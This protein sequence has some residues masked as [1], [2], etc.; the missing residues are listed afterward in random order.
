MLPSPATRVA[1]TSPPNLFQLP[2]PPVSARPELFHPNT[3]TLT[4]TIQAV[5]ESSDQGISTLE[6]DIV[7]TLAVYDRY[8]P[9]ERRDPASATKRPAHTITLRLPHG[10]LLDG[11]A[12]SLSPRQRVRVTGYLR[13]HLEHLSLQRIWAYLKL[14]ERAQLGDDTRLLKTSV[15]H[16]IVESLTPLPDPLAA[17]AYDENLL[18]LSGL[19]QRI[20]VPAG[21]RSR[22]DRGAPD[23]CVRFATYDRHAE[24][25]PPDQV[26]TRRRDPLG[27][28]PTRQAHYTTLRFPN[29][30]TLNGER[31]ALSPNAVLR[32]TGYV[33]SIPYRQSLH[34]ILTRLQQ[35]DRLQDDDAQRTLPRL[36]PHLVVTSCICFGAVRFDQLD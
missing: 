1:I 11:S 20:W 17:D 34:E 31:I 26:G 25:I 7:L 33:R 19:A 18:N 2:T 5:H 6:P 30:R 28:L 24:I 32:V 8:A 14:L 9:S 3:I 35:I 22:S 36:T 16:V 4:G 29:G 15:T 27:Q 10:R 23:V 13:D 12:L 21:A